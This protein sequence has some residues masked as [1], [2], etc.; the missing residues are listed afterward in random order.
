MNKDLRLAL[1][2]A[3]DLDL[4]ATRA[5]NSFYD[6]GIDNGFGDDDFISPMRLLV[7]AKNNTK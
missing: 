5:V 1:E 6:K 2:T 4:P 3:G 7:A